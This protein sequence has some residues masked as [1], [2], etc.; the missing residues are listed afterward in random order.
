M[1]FV[2][3]RFGPEPKLDAEEDVTYLEPTPTEQTV[4]QSYEETN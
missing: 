3:R 2:F 4:Y 1:F